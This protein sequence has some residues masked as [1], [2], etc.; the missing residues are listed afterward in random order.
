MTRQSSDGRNQIDIQQPH[1]IGEWAEK[2][3]VTP[4]E[5]IAAVEKVGPMLDDVLQELRKDQPP[6][7]GLF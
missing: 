2:L 3:G 5:L 1:A 7:P 6:H 4:D